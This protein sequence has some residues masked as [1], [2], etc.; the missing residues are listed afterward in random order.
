MNDA[1]VIAAALGEWLL[2]DLVIGLVQR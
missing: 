2:V 1:R